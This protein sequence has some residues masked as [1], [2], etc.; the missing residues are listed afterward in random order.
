MQWSNLFLWLFWEFYQT[1]SQ[2]KLRQ[3][4]SSWWK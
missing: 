4:C 1:G 3:F 2:T